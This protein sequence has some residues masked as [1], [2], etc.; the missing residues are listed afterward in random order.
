MKNII[1]YSRVSTEEQKKHGFSLMGQKERLFKFAQDHGYKILAYYAED[2]SAKTFNRPQ[3]KK[4][5]QYC[6][7]Y[8]KKI[9]KLVFTKWDRFSRNIQE[10]YKEIDWFR[11]RKIEVYSVDN[12]LDFSL[13][14]SKITLAVYLALSEIENDKISIRVKE[15]LKKAK[16]EGCW[17]C[18][19]P[20]GYTNYRTLEGKSTLIPD[21][22]AQYVLDTFLLLASHKISIRQ[23]WR[24]MRKK[25]MFISSSQ[26][27][28]LVRNPVYIGKIILKSYNEKS[29]ETIEGLHPPIV[30]TVLFEKV[31]K[32]LNARSNKNNI[33]KETKGYLYPLRGFINCSRCGTV[34]TAS[35]STGSNPN[36]E[37]HYYH[38]RNNGCRERFPLEKAHHLF[39]QYLKTIDINK[40]RFIILKNEIKDKVRNKEK[41]RS[42]KIQRIESKISKLQDVISKAEDRLF[43]GLIDSVTF[44]NSKLRY[45][46]K[47]K[48][49]QNKILALKNFNPTFEF[50]HRIQ[51]AKKYIDIS[52]KFKEANLVEKRELLK[53]ILNK[54]ISLTLYGL[55]ENA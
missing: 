30:P 38:C 48:V 5:K 13:P 11:E 45:I 19:P 51:K 54:N 42:E 20:Y 36:K 16:R 3:W 35:A 24:I 18:S 28:K 55:T 10:A 32:K 34:L 22:R 52:R 21:E 37:Y 27:Y 31:Q 26:F 15:S 49:C 39:Y 25:E 9:N 41:S 46:Q 1:T 23:A 6:E 53:S 2:Y 29:I 47:I 33:R 12:P 17:V 8:H 7:K 14:E 4:L 50:Q 44:K 43:E 40:E